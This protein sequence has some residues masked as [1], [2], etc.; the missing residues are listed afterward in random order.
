MRASLPGLHPTTLE[1]VHR[2]I[3]TMYLGGNNITR[4]LR[5]LWPPS[6]A[7]I[8]PWLDLYSSTSTKDNCAFLDWEEMEG[9][10][11]RATPE[12]EK[13]GYYYLRQRPRIAPYLKARTW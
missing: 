7:P 10:K 2:P 9:Y 5:S 12:S 1:L 11:T 6:V 8:L 3:Y 13:L 4:R